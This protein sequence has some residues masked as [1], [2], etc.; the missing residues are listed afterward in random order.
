MSVQLNNGAIYQYLLVVSKG[1]SF[2]RCDV[3]LGVQLLIF[4]RS[5]APDISKD[6]SAFVFSVKQSKNY[7]L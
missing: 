4:Q 2:L 7:Y 5:A 3:L 1:S 6:C